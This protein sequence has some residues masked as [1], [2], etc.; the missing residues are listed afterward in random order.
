MTP[1][2]QAALRGELQ[3]DPK[4]RGYAQFMPDAPGMVVQLLSEQVDTMIKAVKTTTAQAW[5]AAGPYATIF[6]A[7]NDVAHACRSSC[8]MFRGTLVSG[9]DIDIGADD[10]QRM[11]AAWLATGVV[12]QA[13]VNELN[14]RA[15][16]PAS[17]AEVLGLGAVTEDD[18]RTAWQP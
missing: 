10:V 18:V 13:Q 6:D 9:V 3:G 11:F 4:A 5:A 14:E 1:A 2:Q 16:Q 7:G 8:L 17:R 12:T 15:T